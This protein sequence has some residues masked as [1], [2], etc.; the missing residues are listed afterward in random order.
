M[1]MVLTLA[2]VMAGALL[3][4]GCDLEDFD[5]YQADFH[6]H[7]D[8]QSGGRLNVENANGSVEIEGWDRNEVEISGVKYASRQSLLDELR[9]E[10]HNSP[11]A[12]SIRTVR[13]Y[14]PQWSAGARYTIRVP[15]TTVVDRISTSNGPIRVRDI[16]SAGA[17]LQTLN[18]RTSNGL[19]RAE[20]VT[21]VI[22]AQTSNGWVR[23]GRDQRRCDG[24]N[25]ERPCDCPAES[26]YGCAVARY[27]QQW[28]GRSDRA[29]PA[30]GFNSRRNQQWKYYAASAR[31]GGGAPEGRHFELRDL[32]R[33]RCAG[34][35]RRSWPLEQSCRW[36]AWQWGAGDRAF[37]SQRAYQHFEESVRAWLPAPLQCRL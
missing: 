20:N 7:Y 29:Q 26:A 8:L 2:P 18:L 4:A 34:A 23:S 35:I 33:F 17:H 14:H 21:G 24:E 37:D 15:R 31:A 6:Y 27:H 5:S 30:A 11:D 22:D 9:I 25:F 10:I 13:P 12:I 32:K 19:I 28:R 1:R 36:K 3:L 16:G